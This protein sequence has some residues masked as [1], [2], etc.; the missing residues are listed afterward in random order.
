MRPTVSLPRLAIAGLVLGTLVATSG[1]SW[2]RRSNDLYA[3]PPED[4][5]LEV[6]PEMVATDAAA[7][8]GTVTASGTIAA[9]QEARQAAVTGFTVEEADRDAVYA[10]VDAALSG[11][12]GVE[13]ASR[14]ELLGAFD[15]DYRGHN[16][17]V[18]VTGDAG[19]VQVSAMDPR[20]APATG[21][22]VEALMA[23][24]EAEVAG[25]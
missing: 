21:P 22:E 1:C 11:M 10:A 15:L 13:I 18:R 14:T 19:R 4:R 6:P 9:A 23:T 24:L 5:P 12:E 16:F 8:T 20:G 3:M 2:F 25:R 7:E 17:L